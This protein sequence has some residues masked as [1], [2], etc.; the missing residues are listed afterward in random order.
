MDA[1][2]KLEQAQLVKVKGTQFFK[3]S[4]IEVNNF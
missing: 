4:S 2:E 3:V 1:G